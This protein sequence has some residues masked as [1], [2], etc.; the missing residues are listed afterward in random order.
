M[1]LIDFFM[2][3]NNIL[4]CQRKVQVFPNRFSRCAL[5]LLSNEHLLKI[6]LVNVSN[7]FFKLV[8]VRDFG[9]NVA[10]ISV[11][12]NAIATVSDKF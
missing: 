8:N 4:D 10:D 6:K 3:L 7:N 11:I 5:W 2:L 9:L 12:C 1:L